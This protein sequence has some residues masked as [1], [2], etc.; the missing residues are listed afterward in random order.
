M[1]KLALVALLFAGTVFAQDQPPNLTAACGPKGVTFDVK[2]D[3]SQHAIAQPAPGKALVYIISKSGLACYSGGWCVMKAA[4]DGAW[5]GAFKGEP[6]SFGNMGRVTY[7][8]YFYVSVEP[9]EHHMCV[10]AQLGKEDLV[11][12]SHF[13]VEAGK[14]YFRGIQGFKSEYSRSID[15]S[16]LDSDEARYLIATSPLSVSQPVK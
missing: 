12:L 5:V 6:P 10:S 13:T 4:L 15:I 8:S 9:G 7:N 1:M 16:P 11:V 3:S 14:T 2:E